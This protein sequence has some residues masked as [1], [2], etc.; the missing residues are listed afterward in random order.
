MA[1]QDMAVWKLY[2][3]HQNITKNSTIQGRKRILKR[4]EGRERVME[5]A[6]SNHGGCSR[7][8]PDAHNTGIYSQEVMTRYVTLEIGE[9]VRGDRLLFQGL[10][11]L[12]R[13]PN[14]T[15][16]TF[17]TSSVKGYP[18]GICKKNPS[19]MPNYL[20]END[21]SSHFNPAKYPVIIEVFEKHLGTYYV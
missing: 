11:Y 5:Y 21:T 8:R 15:S 10:F 17:L 14:L 18:S 7:A 12:I 13:Y 2:Y 3:E 9:D 19:L 16:A 20:H 6:Q 1:R 4:I